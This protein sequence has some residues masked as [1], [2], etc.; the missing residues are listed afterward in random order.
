MRPGRRCLVAAC[1]L[2]AAVPRASASTPTHDPCA[3]VTAQSTSRDHA[4]DR[5]AWQKP[6]DR[7]V[8]FDLG[9]MTLGRAL[10]RVA[11]QTGV[12]FSYSPE[13]VPVQRTVCLSV[14]EKPLGGVLVAL[15]AG[16]NVSPV[17]VGADQIVL[18]PSRSAAAA[19][20]APVAARSTRVLE[21]V[22]VTGTSTGAPERGSPFSI[23]RVERSSLST[24]GNT[25]LST[26]MD[27]AMP[28]IW[29]WAQSPV[30][31][32]A[33]YG[34]IRGASSFGVST[35]KIYIDGIEVANPLL[36]TT[37][38]PAQIEYV[39]VIRGPQG[40]ALYGSDAISG[41]VNIQM[42][43][44]GN[45][46]GGAV[47]DA[48]ASAG[49]ATSDYVAGG[50]LAQEYGATVRSGSPARSL[51][52]S[53]SLSRIGE[54][55]PGASATQA[56]ASAGTR[57][58]GSQVIVTGTGRIEA[59]N[60][61]SPRSPVLLAYLPAPRRSTDSTQRVR[62]Y[63]LGGTATLQQNDEWLHA[64]TLGIDGYRLTGTA[65]DPTPLPS[66]A[67]SALAAAR[68]GA[69]RVTM[70]LSSTR[71]LGGDA[72]DPSSIGF[73]LEHSSAR[74]SS[75]GVG[76][77][78]APRS[79]GQG[80]RGGRLVARGDL[81]AAQVAAT[82]SS[83]WNNTGLYSQAH[84][85]LT[86]A[87][88]VTGGARIEHMSGPSESGRL[89]LLPMLGAAWIGESG[90][91]TLKARA[92]YGRGIRPART[93]ARGASFTGGRGPGTLTSLA[94][95]EQAGVEAGV[96]LLFGP[97]FGVHVTR[98]DQRASGLVQPVAILGVYAPGNNRPGNPEPARV[99]YQLQNVGAIDNSGW[100]LQASS[101]F[102]NLTLTGALSFVNS[103]VA[104]LAVGYLGDLH[105]G[106]RLLEVPART[107][108][109]QARW[110]WSRMTLNGSVARASDWINYD[111]VALAQA[112]AADPSGRLVPV[113]EALRAYWRTYEGS[114]RLGATA[115][116]RVTDRASLSLTGSNLLNHQLGEPD[117]ITV[118]PG[119]SI[120]FGLQTTF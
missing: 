32:L 69:D 28:G 36:L 2:A 50:V 5:A 116:F 92:A 88:S 68:G 16:T 118:V 63:T 94:P 66:V 80:E 87:L 99:L 110:T 41:V 79:E 58:V 23:S 30:N 4:S 40:A 21:R 89:A 119:R 53:L 64:A 12:H 62:Q 85:A 112:V 38:D 55:T 26:L 52:T 103:R 108:S 59:T 49:G 91:I 73:G 18:A 76:S 11:S 42:R 117:N 24:T 75:S 33:R 77:V 82:T 17:V 83:W 60:A 74:E 19:D 7:I 97:V 34:S 35:P 81:Q 45:D 101:L 114:T 20:A 3:G 100:E 25:S 67:D 104:N 70:R 78:L 56:L 107:A 39:E 71:Q 113:G 95:E 29:A 43:H 86:S 120:L 105:Q 61:Q 31:A 98:F 51:S 13:L 96:D 84:L 22:V 9:D 57:Y 1:A 115:S 46:G 72:R 111:Q 65:G 47:T 106:D 48:R 44:D 109:V 54:F 27:A 37:L 93:V 14:D 8:T 102:G 6:L 90:D 10:D 15:L